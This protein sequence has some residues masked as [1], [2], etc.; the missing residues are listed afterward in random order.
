MKKTRFTEIQII[1]ALKEEEGG[2]SV[3]DI[4]MKVG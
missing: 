2:R 4:I 1:K 3:I